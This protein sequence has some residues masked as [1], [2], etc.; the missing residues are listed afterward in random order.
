MQTQTLWVGIDWGT[1]AHQ[2]CG[3]DADGHKQFEEVVKQTGEGI[4]AF[5]DRLLE[6]VV[7]RVEA[8]GVAIEAP[9]GAIVEALVERGVAAY[10]INPKQLDR[11]RDRH[12][13]AGA[14][15]DRLDAFVLADSLRTDQKLFRRI[16]LGDPTLVELRAMVRA[17]DELTTD[18]NVLANRLREQLRRYFPQMLGLGDLHD[19]T[20]LWELFEL[21][22]TP[23]LA[24]HLSRAKV[25]ALLK[26]HRIRRYAPE[27]VITALRT[28]PLPVA[29][30]VVEAAR[31]HAAL[32]L[33]RLRVTHEQRRVC[34]Q[35]IEAL[36]EQL[37]APT[38]AEDADQGGARDPRRHRDAAVLLSLPGLGRLNGATMLAEASHA[39]GERDYPSLRTQCGVA[40]VS[41]KTGKQRYPTVSMRYACSHQLRNAVYHW[42]RVSV[43]H[44]PVSREHYAR[45]RRAGHSHGRALRGVA[46]RLLAVLVAML[47]SGSLYD[48]TLRHSSPLPEV[49]PTVLAA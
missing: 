26:R 12:T 18:I 3:V 25:D 42:A 14:K 32:L 16:E 35:R 17:H 46:D 20:W 45:L 34:T 27:D 33:P 49:L 47:K 38:Q 30:G 41:S 48:P 24:A 6:R 9:H 22:S 5:C 29:P 39:L 28:R 43:Q 40:P 10:A 19:E 8:V 13:V 15:D 7:G 1:E 37:C 4:V 31:H 2:V 36:M 21:A 44:D 11:F 23:T